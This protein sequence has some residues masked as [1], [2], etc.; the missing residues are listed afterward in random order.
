MSKI[1]SV[2]V[3]DIITNLCDRRGLGNAYE[4]IDDDIQAELI[5]KWE[6]IVDN[7]IKE[8]AQT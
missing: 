2:I 4:D 5:E 3:A 1:A 7:R 6:S 8:E